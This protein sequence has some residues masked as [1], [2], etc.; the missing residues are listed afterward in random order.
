VSSSDLDGSLKK[1]ETP[2]EILVDYAR[3]RMSHYK[4]RK[5]H[6][7]KTLSDELER[8]AVRM[9]FIKLVMDGKLEIFRKSRASVEHN[10]GEVHGIAEKYWDECLSTKTYSYTS[11]EL[12]KLNTQIENTQSELSKTQSMTI[13]NMWENDILSLD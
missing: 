3:I 12:D 4:L 5:K 9:K 13:A 6:I 11:E 2:E 7:I 10:M 8:L 1:Y